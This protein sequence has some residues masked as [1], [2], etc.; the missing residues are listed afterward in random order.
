M[1]YPQIF[2]IQL[3]SLVLATT[4]ITN[5]EMAKGENKVDII[6]DQSYNLAPNVVRQTE[7]WETKKG[8]MLI[9]IEHYC[10]GHS[11]YGESRYMLLRPPSLDWS[12]LKKILPKSQMG[13]SRDAACQLLSEGELE[14]ESV[15]GYSTLA[16]RLRRY[17][18]LQESTDVLRKAIEL[19]P[20]DA[21]LY[22]NLGSVLRARLQFEEAVIIYRQG[23][24][25]T[26]EPSVLS[27]MYTGLGN[28][29]DDS[30]SF[31]EAIDAYRTAIKIESD[32]ANPH[33]DLA[34]ALYRAGQFDEAIQEC[35]LAIQLDPNY[36]APKELLK[37]LEQKPSLPRRNNRF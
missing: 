28:A 12:E 30:G 23:I 9:V 36:D 16:Y 33:F 37:E 10:P 2:K 7:L 31:E 35:Q 11:N 14:L 17:E 21:S 5:T 20:K 34:I 32:N 3:I 29:L 22:N 18:R 27:T 19:Y 25:L 8:R 13:Q 6:L 4:F 24:E 26:S 15:E 1:N